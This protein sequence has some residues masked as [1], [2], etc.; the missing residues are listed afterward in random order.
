ME[1]KVDHSQPTKK[2]SILRSDAAQRVL[3]FGAL[4]LIFLVFWFLSPYFR[5][6]QQH[7]WPS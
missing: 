1:T 4:I 2:T 5:N 7:Q 6:R 3:A